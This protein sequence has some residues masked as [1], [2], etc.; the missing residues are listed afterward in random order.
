M[1]NRLLKVGAKSTSI[2]AKGIRGARRQGGEDPIMSVQA[3]LTCGKTIVDSNI[4][5][6]FMRCGDGD[7]ARLSL[8]QFIAQLKKKY[9]DSK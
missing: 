6:R 9:K 5:A 2:R 4:E 7:D 8:S 3:R 1:A